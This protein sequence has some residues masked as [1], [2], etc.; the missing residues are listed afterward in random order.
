VVAEPREPS[1][2]HLGL[3]DQLYIAAESRYQHLLLRVRHGE[4][5]R[6]TEV[7]ESSLA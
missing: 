5:F 6:S 7:E 3:A 2:N 4:S 1:G